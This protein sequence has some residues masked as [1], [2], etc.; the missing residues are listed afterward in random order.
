VLVVVIGMPLGDAPVER[1][2]VSQPVAPKGADRMAEAVLVEDNCPAPHRLLLRAHAAPADLASLG[3]REAT[4]VQSTCVRPRVVAFREPLALRET[5]ALHETQAL[6]EI[7]VCRET[8]ARRETLVLRENLVPTFG[9]HLRPHP[10]AH[11]GQMPG[12]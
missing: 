4:S 8:W 2:A 10:I 9:H 7:P 11:P 12:L 6:R 3:I 1:K 5:Q